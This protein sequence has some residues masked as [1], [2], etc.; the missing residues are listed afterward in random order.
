MNW[1]QRADQLRFPGLLLAGFV[2][3]SINTAF[4]P[5]GLSLLLLLGLLLLPFSIVKERALQM[6]AVFLPLQYII[7]EILYNPD[8]GYFLRSS[9]LFL[10]F[11]TLGLQA[12]RALKG[13][14]AEDGDRKLSLFAAQI[15][16]AHALL[17]V[18]YLLLW[19]SPWKD[20]VWWTFFLSPSVGD[21]TRLK[22]LGYEP[23]YYALMLAPFFLFQL[24]RV[25]LGDFSRKRWLILFALGLGLLFSFSMGVLACLFLSL[26]IALLYLRFT[27]VFVWKLPAKWPWFLSGFAGLLVLAFLLFPDAALFLRLRDILSGRDLS[28]NNRLLE[29]FMLAGDILGPDRIWFGLGPG[30][31]KVEGYYFIKSFYNYQWNDSWAPSMPNSISDWLCNFGLFGVGMKLLLVFYLYRR[32]G[33]GRDLFRF[34]CFIFIFIYQFT[35][36]YLFCLPELMLW[37]LAFS[38]SP[39]SKLVTKDSV[40]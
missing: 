30:Q 16:S 11:C 26:T 29:S 12:G 31:L 37:V 34:L 25:L 7:A 6:I 39:A 4:T 36:G 8:P 20:L 23:S 40:C 22:G 21:F 24:S 5:H 9:L 13:L 1:K 19:F 14:N 32:Q 3:I 33:S 18:F 2:F 15:S 27:A 10:S 35:G 28:A 38:G 17:L